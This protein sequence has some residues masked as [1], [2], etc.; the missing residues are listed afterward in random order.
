VGLPADGYLPLGIVPR[1]FGGDSDFSMDALVPHERGRG[2]ALLLEHCAAVGR[3]DEARPSPLERLEALVG[4]DL[5][6]MLLTALIGERG[7]RRRP[8]G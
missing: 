3:L 2:A 6:R 1:G 4:C 7:V 5:A 8:F